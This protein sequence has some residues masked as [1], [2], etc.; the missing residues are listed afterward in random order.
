MATRIQFLGH[1]ISAEGIQPGEEKTKCIN[2]FP[3]PRTPTEVRQFLGLAGFFRKFVKG[4]SIIA[5]PL[6]S[7][8]KKEATFVWAEEQQQAFTNLKQALTTQ[9]VL[10]M[11]DPTKEH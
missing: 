3:Q 9:P 11:F 1:V 6:A 5:K 7:L 10:V 2:D 4:Y 8:L